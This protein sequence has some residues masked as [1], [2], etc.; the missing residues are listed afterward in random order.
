MESPA[1][2]VVVRVEPP[3]LDRASVDR[4]M[5]GEIARFE[6]FLQERQRSQGLSGN[7]PLTTPERG[8]LK[9]YITYASTRST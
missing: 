6:K 7:D 9:A 4:L 8:I 3:Q 2:K 1:L 5:D